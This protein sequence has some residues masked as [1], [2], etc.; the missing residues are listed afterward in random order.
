MGR[1]R[2]RGFRTKETAHIELYPE[3]STNWVRLKNRK[4][5]VW[6]EHSQRV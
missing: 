2:A 1:Y 5:T 4:T 3:V 6:L